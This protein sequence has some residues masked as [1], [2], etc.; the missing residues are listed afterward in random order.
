MF[1]YRQWWFA[2]LLG[3]G[4]W[5]LVAV[6]F[7]V[8]CWQSATFYCLLEVAI[9]YLLGA[10]LVALSTWAIITRKERARLR[11]WRKEERE[12][13]RERDKAAAKKN[14]EDELNRKNI[15]TYL[16]E[17]NKLTKFGFPERD[18][19]IKNIKYL[20]V[21]YL[22]P[23]GELRK[24]S[25][26]RFH[27][28]M[29]VLDANHDRPVCWMVYVRYNHIQHSGREAYWSDAYALGWYGSYHYWNLKKATNGWYLEDMDYDTVGVQLENHDDIV[30][31]LS[32]VQMYHSAAKAELARIKD[33]GVPALRKSKDAGHQSPA[34]QTLR[35]M[36]EAP[37]AIFARGLRV[38][39]DKITD[40]QAGP[41]TVRT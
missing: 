12:H 14:K 2:A 39:F 23:A 25:A 33:Y 30:E 7:F 9:P 26:E 15:D 3:L 22:N 19:D 1:W 31:V 27:E 20:V 36:I 18:Y 11:Q 10:E 5:L 13:Q 38:D 6:P 8:E 4:F 41:P 34:L 17:Y 29:R 40:P 24:T 35:W 16:A 28:M 37:G 32:F 21:Y